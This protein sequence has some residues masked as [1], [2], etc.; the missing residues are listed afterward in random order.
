MDVAFDNLVDCERELLLSNPKNKHKF[1]GLLMEGLEDGLYHVSQCVADADSYF[2]QQAFELSESSH[3]CVV[4]ED[5]DML[6][7]M[8]YHFREPKHCVYLRQ[9]LKPSQTPL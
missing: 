7:V 1:I 6:I 5:T 9:S 3:V 8:L 4:S 2:V